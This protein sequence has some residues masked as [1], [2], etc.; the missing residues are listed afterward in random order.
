MPRKDYDVFIKSANKII[1]NDFF[2]QSYQSEKK[3]P[4]AFSKVR[5]NNTA[6]I[7]NM[8]RHLNIN[9]GIYIDVFPI[10]NVADGFKGKIHTVLDKFFSFRISRLFNNKDR[11]FRKKILLFF[12]CILLPSVRLTIKLR[13]NNN[14]ILNKTSFISI[15]GGKKS[16]KRIP[17]KWFENKKSQFFCDVECD[18][19]HM[20]VDYLNQIYYGDFN[21][22]DLL[23]H[24][25]HDENFVEMNA[26]LIDTDQSYLLYLNGKK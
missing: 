5:H 22:A 9:Q 26:D 19:P 12:S 4:L 23:E 8:T 21:S 15:T 24:R 20:F 18:I 6:Y 2:V 13:E 10:D 16:E 1:K 25:F 14:R 3:Y 11:P 17:S 7:S